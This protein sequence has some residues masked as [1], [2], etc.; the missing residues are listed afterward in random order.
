MA[1]LHFAPAV[2]RHV[3]AP[4]ETVAGLTVRDALDDY[5]TRH[6]EVRGYVLDERGVTRK[7]IAIFV[8]G[9]PITDRERQS[10]PAGPT[11][12]IHVIQALSGG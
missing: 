9:D 6:P 10:D 8:D 2:R 3:D 7:H 12:E 11:A 5:F 1:Q 4:S